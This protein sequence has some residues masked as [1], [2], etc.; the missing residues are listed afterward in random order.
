MV[1][2]TLASQTTDHFG[3][4]VHIRI[5]C[6][7]LGKSEGNRFSNCHSRNNDQ[8]HSSVLKTK[9]LLLLMICQS[10]WHLTQIIISWFS[11][12][13]H[14]GSGSRWNRDNVMITNLICIHFNQALH[15]FASSA[16]STANQTFVLF[17]CGTEST[18]AAQ[19]LEWKIEI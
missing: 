1:L 14:N 18:I 3:V 4:Y 7:P 8:F 15:S 10:V 5:K 13:D 16:I 11:F 19:W 2:Y 6:Q 9:M 12:L 17:L